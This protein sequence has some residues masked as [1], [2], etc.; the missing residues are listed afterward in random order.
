LKRIIIEFLCRHQDK[1][2]S[3]KEISQALSLSEEDI[4]Y[5]MVKLGLSD[6]LLE[7]TGFAHR[8]S[9]SASRKKRFKIADVTVQ[10]ITYYRCLSVD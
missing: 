9:N 8:R 6:F 7:L 2:F 3:S 5:A 1:G 10:G 4:N